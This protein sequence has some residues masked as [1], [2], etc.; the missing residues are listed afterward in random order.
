[1]FVRKKIK[2][3]SLYTA[4]ICIEAKNIYM[5]YYDENKKSKYF[6]YL[7]TNNLY[8]WA[9]SLCQPMDEF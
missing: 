1:M 7:D 6:T 4:Q 3:E 5:S 2:G 8:D 9:I